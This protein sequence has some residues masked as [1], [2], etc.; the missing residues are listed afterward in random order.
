[1]KWRVLFCAAGSALAPLMSLAD[2][3]PP[4]ASVA[5]VLRAAPTVRAAAAGLRAEEANR[6]RLAA[7]SYEWTLRLTGQRR[8]A[9]PANAPEESYREQQLAV[10]RPFRLP[11]KAALDA[12]L[13]QRGLD[14]ARAAY[15]DALHEA[16][17][18]LLKDWFAW[19]REGES[20]RQWA[21]QAALLGRQAAS[22]GRRQQLGDA[23]RLETIQA[24]AALAQAEAALAQARA[25]ERSAA[26]LLRRRYPGL[27]LPESVTL[28]EPRALDGGGD[29]WLALLLEHSHEV[30]IARAEAQ[31]AL[32]AARR[33][34]SEVLPDPSFGIHAGRERGGEERVVGF[35]LAVALPGTARRAGA[36]AALAQA[37]A[38]SGREAAAVQKVSA[39]AA[40]L[41]QMAS[42]ARENWASSRLAA[43]RLDS[44]AAMTERA[45]QLGE[46]SL[47]DLL[48]ARRLANEAR[49]AARLAQ[50][51]ALES[52]WRLLLDA[53]RLWDFD[54]E[55][56]AR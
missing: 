49:L 54:D 4:A 44:A 9:A 41:Y 23:A 47:N 6:E 13:G 34:G 36:E 56:G 5:A 10:E 37:E 20:A 19:L 33:A 15:G 40:G 42:T 52:R 29:D 7:G 46:G 30:A 55:P 17:R 12:E 2:E 11:G 31:L 53:H 50:L 45:Y 39:E 24:E 26:E 32:A 25:R 8:R 3:L 43:D 16:G 14:I 51:D 18:S 27:T 48:V 28:S 1:M 38:A 21:E 35:S 22:V